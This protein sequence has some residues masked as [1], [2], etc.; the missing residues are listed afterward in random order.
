MSILYVIL[1]YIMV[2]HNDRSSVRP[3]PFIIHINR[4]STA[5]LL[6]EV[7]LY[8]D[9]TEIYS[10]SKDIEDAQVNVYQDLNRVSSWFNE[11]GLIVSTKKSEAM[12][13]KSA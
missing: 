2:S 4:L 5:C 12:L 9:D 1:L 6:Y 3:A 11:N 10:S 7:L 8:A 13:I